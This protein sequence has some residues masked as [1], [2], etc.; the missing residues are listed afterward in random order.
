MLAAD[1]G[2]GQPDVGLGAAADDVATGGQLV[3]GARAVD[4]QRVGVAR[5]GPAGRWRRDLAGV[6]DAPAQRGRGGS[7][8]WPG[9]GGAAA[10]SARR[11]GAE[12][13]ATSEDTSKT[14][15][16]RSLSRSR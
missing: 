10:A 5:A 14:P 15:V 2:V 7:G 6:A 12:G 4:D 11:P 1:A 8:G 3:P 13:S 16:G 9:R